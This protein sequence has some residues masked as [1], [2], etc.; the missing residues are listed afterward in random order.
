MILA[1]HA[2][3][4]SRPKQWTHHISVLEPIIEG[5][6]DFPDSD[7]SQV[8]AV[9]SELG[10]LSHMTWMCCFACLSVPLV[11]RSVSKCFGICVASCSFALRSP[12]RCS[13]S[14]YPQCDL[15][16]GLVTLRAENAE[17]KKTLEALSVY[18]DCHICSHDMAPAFV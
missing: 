6:P 8:T 9:C 4:R 13:H 15:I 5:V 14:R 12:G 2:S 7:P 11:C 10:R 1:N 16:G 3:R 18:V 17:L